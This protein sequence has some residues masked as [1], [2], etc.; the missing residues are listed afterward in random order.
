[1]T[2]SSGLLRSMRFW[3]GVSLGGL[4]WSS[5]YLTVPVAFALMGV[6]LCCGD[7][8]DAVVSHGIGDND[9]EAVDEAD[10]DPAVFAIIIA[11]FLPIQPML[12]V[13]PMWRLLEPRS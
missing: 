11:G 10:S 7:D 3:A 4:C 2:A 12:I 9:F 6:C 5:L 13:I 1:M 8:T